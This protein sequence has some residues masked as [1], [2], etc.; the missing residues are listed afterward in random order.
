MKKAIKNM[1]LT[2]ELANPVDIMNHVTDVH[3]NIL[4]RQISGYLRYLDAEYIALKPVCR[5]LGWDYPDV[6]KYLL[7]QKDAPQH[8]LFSYGDWIYQST[9]GVHWAHLV[10][11][12]HRELPTMDNHDQSYAS[13]M[14]L[15]IMKNAGYSGN[16]SKLH[17]GFCQIPL[18]YFKSTHL[19]SD[20]VNYLTA[21][22]P[23]VMQQLEH[24]MMVDIAYAD[25]T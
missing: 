11:W 6:M 10:Q 5:I 7:N 17:K 13:L 22:F 8:K 16:Q 25:A 21:A 2:I 18:D 9:W 24:E 23:E 4:E 19:Y 14:A 1:K 20:L 15:Q 3:D 12:L